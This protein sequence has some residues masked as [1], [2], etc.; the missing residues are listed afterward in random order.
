MGEVLAAGT[1]QGFVESLSVGEPLAVGVEVDRLAV[2]GER[3][4]G[5]MSIHGRVRESVDTIHRR[6]LALVD[7][8]GIAVRDGPVSRG[9]EGD[10][11][12]VVE[13]DDETLG[14]RLL[15]SSQG[16]VLD[17]GRGRR[18]EVDD[19]AAGVVVLEE[20]DAVASRV[21]GAARA[22]ALAELAQGAA[23]G[24]DRLVEPAGVLVAIGEDELG[25]SGMVPAI[26]QVAGDE[27]RPGALARLAPVEP[28]GGVI[29]VESRRHPA[30]GQVLG[31]RALPGFGLAADRL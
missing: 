22:D 20:D 10:A 29:A 5:R 3:H 9:I 13:A 11:P 23:G 15:D 14:L 1:G 12:A 25:R 16:A 31:G 27:L 21:L 7:G 18:V 2:A 19:L 17:A 6:A 8:D 4:V 26:L 24:A 30:A 28:A